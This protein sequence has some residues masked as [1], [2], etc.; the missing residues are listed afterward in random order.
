[1]AANDM[2]DV[3]KMPGPRVNRPASGVYGEKASADRLA[4]QLPKAQ[5]PSD[6]MGPG[7]GAAP[8]PSLP[9]GGGL[10]RPASA[11]PTGLPPGLLRPSDRPNEPVGTP[12]SG[13][14][15]PYAGAVD[16]RQRRMRLLDMLSTHPEASPEMRE[17]ATIVKQK[18]ISSV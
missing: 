4:A 15:D 6:V 11:A 1:M 14:V 12:L 10:A 5:P 13:P 3:N 18:L 17:W 16:A 8:A 9:G 7:P 2:P